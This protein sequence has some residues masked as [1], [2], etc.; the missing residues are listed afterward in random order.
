[1]ECARLLEEAKQN[2]DNL[3][4]SASVASEIYPELDREFSAEIARLNGAEN[5]GATLDSVYIRAT[6]ISGPPLRDGY[7]FAQTLVNDYG[8]PF[9]EGLNN[10]VGLSSYAAVGPVSLNFR[11]EYQNAGPSPSEPMAA[12]QQI[13]AGED[14]TP[15]IPN[16]VSAVSRGRLLDGSLGITFSN[17]QISL[18][19]ESLWLGPGSSGPFLFSDN[20]EPILMLRLD[21]VSPVY[22]PG[23]S[24]ILGPIR[25]EFAIGRMAGTQWVFSQGKLFGPGISNQPFV[26]VE[27]IGFKPTQ[28]FEFGM[29]V[30]SVFGGPGSP[31]TF[32]NFLKTYSVRCSI[33]SCSTSLA[34]NNYGDRRSTVDFTYRIPH[35]RDWITV[36]GDSLVED[37]VSPIGSSRP[38]LNLGIYFPKI[39]KLNKLDL[40][41]ESI[42]TD[43]PNTVFIGNYYANSHYLSGYTNYGMIMGNWIGR[44]G[45]G[46]QVWTTYHFTPRTNLQL[47]YRREIVS[48]KFLGGGGLID[49][50]IKAELT[51]TPGISLQS[52]VQYEAWNFP[53]LAPAEKSNVTASM[54]VNFYPHWKEKK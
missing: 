20:A 29:G 38:A 35:L 15:A 26:H 23:L 5:F 31:V 21:R 6:N 14:G 53:A 52:F 22:V 39:P 19:K 49:L 40:R 12:L 50:G 30:S 1:M 45:K 16:G 46:G 54:Q 37:E 10:V 24:R 28:N 47:Q 43:A 42:Y 7:H 34:A 48:Q 41:A 32:G 44:A 51:L 9:A 25:T 11:G 27:K 36:Y 3:D 13:A 2:V 33:G 8:R 4:D 18:G 17:F